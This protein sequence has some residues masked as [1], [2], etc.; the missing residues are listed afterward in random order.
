MKPAVESVYRATV[1][2]TRE[3]HLQCAPRRAMR[4]RRGRLRSI[5]RA[6]L[7][8]GPPLPWRALPGTIAKANDLATAAASS[9]GRLGGR[10]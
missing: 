9:M 2:V 4:G 8:A 7:F 6:Q 1:D 10:P 5:D 3:R